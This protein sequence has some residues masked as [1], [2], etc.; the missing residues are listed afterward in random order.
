MLLLVERLAIRII[1]LSNP[2]HK[3]RGGGGR[4]GGRRREGEGIVAEGEERGVKAREVD[5]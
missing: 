3:R 1:I 5:K 2:G 4:E